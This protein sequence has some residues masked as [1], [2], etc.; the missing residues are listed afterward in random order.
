[1]SKLKKYLKEILG[2][3]LILITLALIMIY[4]YQVLSF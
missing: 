2:I 4:F 1:M 3:V